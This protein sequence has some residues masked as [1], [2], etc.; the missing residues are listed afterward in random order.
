M[1]RS[2]VGAEQHIDYPALPEGLAS[3]LLTPR[4]SAEAQEGPHDRI[5]GAAAAERKE[6]SALAATGT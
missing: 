6:I 3:E 2:L 4:T 1:T 5:W